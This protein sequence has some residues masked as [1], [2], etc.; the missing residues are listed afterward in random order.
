MKCDQLSISIVIPAHNEGA[1]IAAT[2]EEIEAFTRSRFDNT[3]II[4]VND[5]SH[6]DT[7]IK[8]QGLQGGFSAKTT[9]KVIDHAH[10]Y[11]KGHSVRSGVMHASHPL[12][13]M[14]DADLSTPIF[15][16]EKLIAIV[17]KGADIA[18]ASRTTCG[19]RIMRRQPVYRRILGRVYNCLVRLLVIDRYGD[20]QCGFKLFRSEVAMDIFS[21]SQI[22]GFAFDVEVLLLAERLGH[23]VMEAPVVWTNK[24]PDSKVTMRRDYWSMLTDLFR[25]RIL[26]NKLQN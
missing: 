1:V 13:L 7:L 14:T 20:T 17:A 3:E 11:G 26:H 5:G 23:K 22:D 19:S 12:I 10:R 6:D 21:R 8:L 16:I 24:S 2:L 15:E 9:L 25:I 18:I 4:V